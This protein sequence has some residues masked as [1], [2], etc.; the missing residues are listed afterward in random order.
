MIAKG[1]IK[2]NEIRIGEMYLDLLNPLVIELTAKFLL[3]HSET[4]LRFGPGSRNT[5]WSTKTMAALQMLVTSMEEDICETLFDGP[6]TTGSGNTSVPTTT[7]EIPS[8]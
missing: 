4:G 8:L 2:L 5:G 1:P 6:T 7:D 3:Q